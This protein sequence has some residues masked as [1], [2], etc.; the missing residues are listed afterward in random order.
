MAPSW[1]NRAQAATISFLAT[2]FCVFSQSCAAV[3]GRWNFSRC[4]WTARAATTTARSPRTF[5]GFA[6]GLGALA[7]AGLLAPA[8]AAGL[9]APA[10]SPAASFLGAPRAAPWR[11][12]RGYRAPRAGSDFDARSQRCAHKLA[13]STN[14]SQANVS[15]SAG[16]Q[17]PALRQSA[18]ARRAC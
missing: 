4:C 9:R 13:G 2:T 8:A 15:T 6:L 1:A 14:A 7:A 12:V 16:P 11:L 17:I 5:W 10:A 3:K 18:S